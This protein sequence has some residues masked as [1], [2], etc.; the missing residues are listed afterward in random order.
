MLADS[1]AEYFLLHDI[2][3]AGWANA[4]PLPRMGWHPDGSR[5]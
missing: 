2:P 3:A 5:A 1:N 4:A